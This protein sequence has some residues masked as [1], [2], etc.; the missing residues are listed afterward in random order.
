MKRISLIFLIMVLL[1]SCQTPLNEVSDDEVRPMIEAMLRQEPGVL[2]KY[3]SQAL[4]EVTTFEQAESQIYQLINTF[5][6]ETVGSTE[7]HDGMMVTE[8]TAQPADM[9]FTVA[10]DEKNRITGVFI[11]TDAKPQTSEVFYEEAISIGSDAIAGL[12]TYPKNQTNPPV[13]ILISG[14]GPQDRNSM[15]GPNVPFQDLAHGLAAKGIA[16]IRYD[17]R[18]YHD[19][20]LYQEVTIEEEMLDDVSGAIELA[21]TLDIDPDNI[22][23]IGHSLGG[24]MIPKL[25]SDHPEVAG[26]IAMAGSPRPLQEIM[27]D[28]QLAQ[29]ESQGASDKQMEQLNQQMD[30]VN[31]II[32]EIDTPKGADILGVPDR[33]WLSLREA[34]APNHTRFTQPAL[35]LQ[36]GKDFQVSAEVDYPA[37]QEL[38]QDRS[39]VSFQLFDNLNHLFMPSLT[40]DATEYMTPQTVAP[41]VI[42]AISSWIEQQ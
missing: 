1:I 2:A 38:F 32:Q 22:F 23:L 21:R 16:T 8:V 26:G 33:Y 5:K 41:E 4:G 29:M 28:Q 6:I 13:V 42:D 27:R 31:Q 12:I 14:S 36:G 11:K 25:L 24:M 17:D 15:I 18:Y 7:K 40:G 35:I 10:L 34:A 3:G 20:S 19:A 39:D 30:S 37:W 9:I